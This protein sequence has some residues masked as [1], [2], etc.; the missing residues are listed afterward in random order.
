MTL[1]AFNSVF[2]QS[3]T[4]AVIWA[5][6]L[7]TY[8][9]LP[10]MRDLLNYLRDML[11]RQQLGM[12]FNSALAIVGL[13]ILFLTLARRDWK[14]VLSVGTALTLIGLIAVQLKIPEERFH[15]LQYGLLGVLVFSTAR[16]YSLRT[17]V[18]LV[19]FVVAVGIGDETIQWLLPNRVGDLRDVA[20]NSAAGVLGA[21]IGRA[22]FWQPQADNPAES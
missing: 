7:L 4:W 9:T 15:F 21:W 17:T 14:T 13:A 19:L 3:R 12:A 18:L 20:M 5:Y 8:L 22:Y 11:G 6:I 10:V 16:E 2:Y 1:R